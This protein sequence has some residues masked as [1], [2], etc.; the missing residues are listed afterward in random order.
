MKMNRQTLS[1]AFATLALFCAGDLTLVHA[2]ELITNGSFENTNGTFVDEGGGV[3]L[4]ALTPGSTIIPGWTV[5]NDQLA[6]L[7]NGNSTGIST[8]FGSFLLDLT[9]N[10]DNG[11]Y[12]GVTQTIRTIPS[13]TYTLSLSLGAD[14]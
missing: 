8:P 2:Q 3:M 13:E 1:L 7:M 5:T 10:H 9:G 14:Q 11:S 4:T 6:W 12:A